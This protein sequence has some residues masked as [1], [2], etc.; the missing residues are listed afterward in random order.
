MFTHS[1]HERY[2]HALMVH[3]SVTGA[4][5]KRVNTAPKSPSHPSKR[6]P[7]GL[8]HGGRPQLWQHLRGRGGSAW[9]R[10]LSLSGDDSL[11]SLRAVSGMERRMPLHASTNPR[12]LQGGLGPFEA[13]GAE[14]VN[15]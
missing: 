10:S 3:V 8:W 9:G 5:S 6:G 15:P 12:Q 7:A 14:H 13:H 1:P 4:M 11:P 2:H